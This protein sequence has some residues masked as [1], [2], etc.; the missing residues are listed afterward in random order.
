MT[1]YKTPNISSLEAYVE[2]GESAKLVDHTTSTIA[3]I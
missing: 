3:M 2:L 1:R